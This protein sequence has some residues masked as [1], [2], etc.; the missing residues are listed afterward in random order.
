MLKKLQLKP[1][2]GVTVR[3]PETFLPLKANGEVKPDTTYW[4]RR[5]RDGDVEFVTKPTPIGKSNA[6][7]N[8]G[9]PK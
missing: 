2:A 8:G 9:K 1:V 5:L 3:D 4:R 6:K 7:A